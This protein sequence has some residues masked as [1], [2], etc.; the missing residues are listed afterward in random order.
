[1]GCKQSSEKKGPEVKYSQPVDANPAAPAATTPQRYVDPTEG[2]TPSGYVPGSSPNAAARK[3][4]ERNDTVNRTPAQ[5]PSP[6]HL[7]DNPLSASNVATTSKFKNGRPSV[8]DGE[9]FPCFEKGL[10]W[11]IVKDDTWAFYNDTQ[12]Y[13]MYVEFRFGPDST[14]TPLGAAI[15]VDPADGWHVAKV[16]VY[17]GETEL[18]FKGTYNGYTSSIA[19][20]PLSEEYRN[21]VNAAANSIVM[22]ELNAVKALSK[23]GGSDEELLAQCLRDNVPFVDLTFPPLQESL[24]RA[25]IDS[26]QVAPTAWRRPK[27]FLPQE[28]RASIAVFIGGIAPND[29][30][31]GQLGDCW[32]LCAMAAV[33]EFPAK[34]KDMFVHAKS[35][36]V[37]QQEHAAGAYRVV[38][39]KH[40]WWHNVI[41]DDFFP[42]VGPRQCFAHTVETPSEL[43]ASLIEKAYAKLHGSYAS[44]VA[45]D[46]LQALQDLTGFPCHRFDPEWAS[47][48]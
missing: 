24:S 36:K 44:I 30:D 14:L 39:N 31:Q 45:G 7:D 38:I 34:I 1:M 48:A 11:R 40:G 28:H 8:V 10:L 25:K 22:Q 3:S 20:K 47:A 42:T 37:M 18:F 19:A 35:L 27:D 6:Q 46:P 43:W 12:E 41:V 15:T 23:D 9:E 13:E 21:R 17:P 4:T 5:A 32:V 2:V 16:I 26:K 33:A 29:I